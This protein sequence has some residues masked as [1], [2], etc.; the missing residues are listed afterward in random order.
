MRQYPADTLAAGL[1][2]FT[3]HENV[4]HYGVEEFY[5]A[6]LAGEAGWIV[7]E[8][9]AEGRP[10]VL[11]APQMKPAVDGSDLTLISWSAGVHLCLRAAER[12]A[13]EGASVAV[14]DLRS[15]GVNVEIAKLAGKP[16]ATVINAAPAQGAQALTAAETVREWY[17]VEVCPIIVHQR[18]MFGHALVQNKCAQEVEPT[19][20]AATEVA[21]LWEWLAQRARQDQTSSMAAA[22]TRLSA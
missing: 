8:H 14:L 2:G 16:V 5:N 3:D 20:K 4:G 17:G 13:A 11:Q 1:L 9:D 15:I 12:L 6:K 19:S 10:L 18:A 7:A 22:M 21:A